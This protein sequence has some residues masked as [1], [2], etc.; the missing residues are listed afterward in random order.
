MRI[1]C[2]DVR[3]ALADRYADSYLIRFA[4]DVC[5]AVDKVGEP[6]TI[7]PQLRQELMEAI[8]RLIC[9]DAT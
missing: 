3:E 1:L 7:T 4:S 5:E 2:D 8:Q 9:E 6:L